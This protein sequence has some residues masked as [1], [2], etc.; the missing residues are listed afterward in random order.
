MY[1]LDLA[2]SIYL[3]CSRKMFFFTILRLMCWHVTFAIHDRGIFLCEYAAEGPAFG[4][5]VYRIQFDEEFSQ[6]VSL[7]SLFQVL[8]LYPYALIWQFHCSMVQKFKSSSPFG[9][10]Y[11]FH[12]EVFMRYLF[13]SLFS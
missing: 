1:D 10:K 3:K 6:K 12:L 11:N 5:S 2:E 8:G 4:N 9:I 7:F 13:F